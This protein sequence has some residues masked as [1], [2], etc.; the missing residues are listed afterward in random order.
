LGSRL[1]ANCSPAILL[2]RAGAACYGGA[3]ASNP[4]IQPRRG[5][6]PPPDCRRTG[7]SRVKQTPAHGTHA[8][9]IGTVA[10]LSPFL[11]CAA[12]RHSP[13]RLSQPCK[14]AASVRAS[15]L[16]CSHRACRPYGGKRLWQSPCAATPLLRP[17]FSPAPNR[18]G[19]S[20]C[21]PLDGGKPLPQAASAALCAGLGRARKKTAVIICAHGGAG[22]LST[23]AGSVLFSPSRFCFRVPLPPPS[24]LPAV[25]YIPT[26]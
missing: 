14:S 7:Q 17:A 26:L 4:T 5:Q 15:V 3:A 24:R 13:A 12:R 11:R 9:S 20:G 19:E 2:V 10:L 1:P 25:P 23:G 18:R 22:M 6:A 21:R 8:G 16:G